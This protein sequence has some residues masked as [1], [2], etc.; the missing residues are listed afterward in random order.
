MA[1]GQEIKIM[2]PQ[3]SDMPV[4]Y[5]FSGLGAD[6]RAFEK[7]KLP[8]CRWEHINWIS[9]E[10]SESMTQ[11]TSRI[12]RQIIA[13]DPI[14]IGLSFGGMVA[15]E[16]A[17]QMPVKKLIL[18]SSAKIKRELAMGNSLF[19]KWKLYKIIPGL[20]LR[21]PN[22]IADNLFG[23]VSGEDK[24]ILGNILKDSNPQFFRRAMDNI[25]NWHNEIIPPQL[26]HIHGTADKIIPYAAVKADYGIEGGGHLIVLTHAD[27]ISNIILDYLRR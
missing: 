24:K 18:I 6:Y 4:I 26:I 14:I 7:L 20:C 15:V 25:V 22:F 3:N 10:K 12:K 9:P 27:I 23:A 5:F 13:D 21:Q 2:E 1:F 16:L 17:K 19:F 11:Y 8:G